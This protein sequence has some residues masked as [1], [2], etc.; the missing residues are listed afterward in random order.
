MNFFAITAFS[1]AFFDAFVL[2]TDIHFAFLGYHRML[3][4]HIHPLA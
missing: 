1:H 3:A 2:E 4:Y